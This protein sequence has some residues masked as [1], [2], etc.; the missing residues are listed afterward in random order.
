MSPCGARGPGIGLCD[1][2][3]VRQ[4]TR[5]PFPRWGG[6]A[7]GRSLRIRGSWGHPGISARPSPLRHHGSVWR[8]PQEAPLTC[9][10][11]RNG[12]GEGTG[13]GCR[14]ETL[15]LPAVPRGGSHQ[16]SIWGGSS[17]G[18]R[19]SWGSPC[20]PAAPPPRLG[21]SFCSVPPRAAPP[22][23]SDL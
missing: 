23:T 14:L 15:P 11:T 10:W 2:M 12:Q 19:R 21:L 4:A 1:S 22:R 8:S 5:S 9:R 18:G 16:S 6:G 17:A 13:L 7:G 3:G 20:C